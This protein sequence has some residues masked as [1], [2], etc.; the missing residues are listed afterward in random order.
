MRA[1]SPSLWQVIG[2][3]IHAGTRRPLTD[4]ELAA[5]LGPLG[6]PVSARPMSG[7]LFAS[8]QVVRLADGRSVVV[9][10]GTPDLGDRPPLLT[11][12]RDL[13]RSEAALL[14]TAAGLPG[15]PVAEV[16]LMDTD[17][18]HVEVDVMVSELLPG[19]GWSVVHDTMSPSATARAVRDVGTVMAGLHQVVGE[20]FGYPAADFALGGATWPEAFG[21]MM[22]ALLDDAE[23]WGVEVDAPLVRAAVERAEPALAEI[24]APHLLHMDLWPGN[25]LVDRLTGAVTGIVD[26]SGACTATRCS[27]WSEPTGCGSSPWTPQSSRP[28]WTR[29]A[30]SR[31]RKDRNSR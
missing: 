10:T 18:R 2:S 12:E 19:E 9:K 4:A 27:R 5:V 3:D 14:R 30:C 20:R 21:A 23:V 25:V 1:V 17:R 28:T 24:T 22:A 26:P 29:G 6:T 8:V 15:V 7:G 31:S 16:L 13:L 11:Y